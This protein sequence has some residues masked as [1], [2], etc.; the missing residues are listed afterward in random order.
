MLNLLHFKKL[1]TFPVFLQFIKV[2]PT[3]VDN[4]MAGDVH[5]TLRIDVLV[6]S[7]RVVYERD[8]IGG[9]IDFTVCS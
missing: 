1:D 9:A 3:I 4:H 2:A 6:S 8:R 7:T 5:G